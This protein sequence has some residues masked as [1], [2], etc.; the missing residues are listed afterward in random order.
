MYMP[1]HRYWKRPISRIQA[2][3]RKKQCLSAIM[4][5]WIVGNKFEVNLRYCNIRHVIDVITFSKI[6]ISIESNQR[7]HEWIYDG[8]RQDVISQLVG[9]LQSESRCWCV[10][11]RRL[12][13]DKM[14][15]CHQQLATNTR[16]GGGKRGE[17]LDFEINEFRNAENKTCQVSK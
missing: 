7:K 15:K 2:G 1:C 10:C 6:M 5:L 11:M 3:L 13:C 16:Q 12:R 14:R 9:K 8:L 4:A 17:S